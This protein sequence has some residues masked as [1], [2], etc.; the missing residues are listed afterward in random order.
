[1][2]NAVAL[3]PDVREGTYQQLLC[4]CTSLM[5]IVPLVGEDN[6]SSHTLSGV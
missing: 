2:F 3:K 6:L 5:A 1:M 4:V